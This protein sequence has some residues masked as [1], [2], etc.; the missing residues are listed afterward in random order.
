RQSQQDLQRATI[1]AL[2]QVDKTHMLPK[3]D[4]EFPKDWKARPP[5]RS[6]DEVPMTAKEVKLLRALNSTISLQFSNQRLQDVI[7]Y[8]Q[9]RTGQSIILDKT[10]L[11]DA[12]V[13]YDTPVSL[14]LK[15]VTLRTALQKLLRDQGLTYVI[16]DEAIQVVTPTQ[17]GQMLRTQIYYVGDL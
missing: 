15:G 4:I 2:T 5:R 11:E 8:I 13:T 6:S 16:K 3:G 7:E 12:G 17:A 14:S 1:G 10:S 9:D